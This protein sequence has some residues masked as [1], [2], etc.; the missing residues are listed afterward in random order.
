MQSHVRKVVLVAD[1]EPDAVEFVR[2]VLEDDFEVIDAPDGLR[3][4]EEAKARRP[5]LIILDV[6]MPKKDGFTTLYD[7]RQDPATKSIPVVFLTAVTERTGIPFS[8]DAIEE[9]M[10][11]RPEAYV[12]KPIDPA[13]LLGTVRRLTGEGSRGR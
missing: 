2:S 10:G 4:L 5:D 1:D 12:E 3:A 11:E 6:Q 13:H 8:A 9:Y 7:L